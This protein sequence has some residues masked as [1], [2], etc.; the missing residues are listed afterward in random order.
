MWT[1][2]PPYATDIKSV[3]TEAIEA[4][5]SSIKYLS[6]KGIYSKVNSKELKRI[7]ATY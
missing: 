5:S 1:I 4:R 3:W 2:H 6:S 7:K